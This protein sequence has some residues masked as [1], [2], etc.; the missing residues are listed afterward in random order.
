MGAQVLGKGYESGM[1][2]RIYTKA[3]ENITNQTIR[4]IIQD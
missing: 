3:R 2:C 4:V 1:L